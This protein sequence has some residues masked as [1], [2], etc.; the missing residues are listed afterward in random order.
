MFQT[1]KGFRHLA[2]C[3]EIDHADWELVNTLLLLGQFCNHTL[4]IFYQ[5][6]HLKPKK[7]S[8][9]EILSN[10]A[11]PSYDIVS[12]WAYTIFM[13]F[14]MFWNFYVEILYK[15]E[16]NRHLPRGC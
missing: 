2:Y 13:T 1:L 11:Q 8:K 15:G 5:F 3:T 4:Y 7:I 9:F 12:E 14:T 6:Y 16:T 10:D